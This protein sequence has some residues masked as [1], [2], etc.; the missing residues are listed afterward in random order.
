MS[1][2]KKQLLMKNINGTFKY[3]QNLFTALLSTYGVYFPIIFISNSI[4]QYSTNDL[5]VFYYVK[6]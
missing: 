5:G 6:I 3:P 2:F 4:R 1:K